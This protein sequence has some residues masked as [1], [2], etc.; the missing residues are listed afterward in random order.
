RGGQTSEQLQLLGE[1]AFLTEPAYACLIERGEVCACS[2]LL[3]R[4]LDELA[5]VIHGSWPED[6]GDAEG[7]LHLLRD[8]TERRL[9]VH[10][11]LRQH[12]AVDGE[13]D[14]AET[15]DQPAV[16]KTVDARGR[17]DARDPQCPELA[18]LSAPVAICILAGLDDRLLG[19]AIDLAAGVVVALRLAENL[20]VTA[21]RRHA[22]LDSCHGNLHERRRGSTRS[23]R[24]KKCLL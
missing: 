1:E 5:K 13:A 21:P 2:A 14:L 17:I 11:E 7:A 18:L 8:G 6:S 10:G 4:L 16:G 23:P 9:V 3:Q 12:L 20:L 22:T 15:V 19:G 24:K